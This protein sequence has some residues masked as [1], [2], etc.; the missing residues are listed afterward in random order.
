MND[1]TDPRLA[2]RGTLAAAIRELIA[3]LALDRDLRE[4]ALDFLYSGAPL[5]T[6]A[7]DRAATESTGDLVLRCQVSDG[8]KRFLA[9]MRAGS[10]IPYDEVE[11]G[12][13]DRSPQ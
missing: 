4:C 11:V 5:G 3:L 7:I 1:R 9:A 6:L 8:L 2:P 10:R 12:G 13:E